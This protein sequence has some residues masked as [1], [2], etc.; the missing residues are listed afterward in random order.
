MQVDPI[1]PTSK[2]TGNERLKMKHVKLLSTS[3]FK[4]NLRCYTMDHPDFLCPISHALMRDPV[5]GRCGLA[6]SNPC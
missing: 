3:A 6:L 1:K 4:F 5:A 2:P